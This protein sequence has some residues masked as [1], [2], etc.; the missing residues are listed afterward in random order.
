LSQEGHFRSRWASP[1]FPAPLFLWERGWSCRKRESSRDRLK[2]A[3]NSHN[4]PL[5]KA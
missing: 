2:A 3:W 1:R 5:T 4:P